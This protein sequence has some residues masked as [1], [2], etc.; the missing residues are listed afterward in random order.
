MNRREWTTLLAILAGKLVLQIALLKAGFFAVSGDDY[1]RALI[2]AEW[3][4]APFFA[5]EDFGRPSI[6]WLP[7]P[8]WFAGVSN[9]ITGDVW[10]APIIANLVFGLAGITAVYFLTRQLFGSVEAA[11]AAMLAAILPWHAWMSLSALADPPYQVATIVALL[12]LVRWEQGDRKNHKLL[13][14]SSAALFF[15]AMCRPEAW[16]FASAFAAYLAWVFLREKQLR[17]VVTIAAAL[18]FV[19]VLFWMVHN[20]RLHGNPTEFVDEARSSMSRETSEGDSVLSRVA[21]F[22]ILLILVSPI[23]TLIAAGWVGWSVY[24]KRLRERPLVIYLVVSSLAFVLLVAGFVAGMGTNTTPQRF[25]VVFALLAIPIAT[26]ALVHARRRLISLA[27]FAAVVLWSLAGVFRYPDDFRGEAEAGRILREIVAEGDVVMT[28]DN[29]LAAH[30]I[31]P[32]D[33]FFRIRSQCRDWA[34]KA[35]SDYPDN[36]PLK[37]RD[38]CLWQADVVERKNREALESGN[39]RIIIARSAEALDRLPSGF[40]WVANGGGYGIFVKNGEPLITDRLELNTPTEIE[41]GPDLQ[42]IG[43][44]LDDRMFP[45]YVDLSWRLGSSGTPE[46]IQLH[47]VGAATTETTHSPFHPALLRDDELTTRI[48]FPGPREIAPGRYRIE[49]HTS[50][51]NTTLGEEWIVPMKRD[52]LKAFLS[53]ENRDIGMLI[54]VLVS[55]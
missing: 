16:L 3:A 44:T 33:I 19:F 34:I 50:G 28:E 2:A 40:N 29:F 36:F 38:D 45:S 7:A 42:L 1:L 22:P 55:L 41:F 24:R 51:Q 18:P 12:L 13:F 6:L 47:F 35:M 14:G 53:G 48:P 49:L 54:R 8:F 17:L 26:T 9:W 39:V 37:V 43:Y 4:N 5:P 31:V 11:I 21:L 15:G 30:G 10:L 25:V 23:L 52:A 27:V 32:D 20:Y 46:S